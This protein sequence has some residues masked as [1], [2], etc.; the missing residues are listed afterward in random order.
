M[1]GT[2]DAGPATVNIGRGSVGQSLRQ[3]MQHGQQ[4]PI[5]VIQN[6]DDVMQ[7]RVMKEYVMQL[8]EASQPIN[9]QKA[10]GSR[11]EEFFQFCSHCY[12]GDPF[13]HNLTPEK[14]YRFVFF[15][16]F[17]EQKARGGGK[18]KVVGFEPAAYNKVMKHFEGVRPGQSVQNFPQPTNPISQSSFTTYKAVLRRIYTM[19]LSLGYISYHWDQLWLHPCKLVEQHV[20]ERKADSDKRLFKEK[21]TGEFSPY[22]VADKYGDIK[23][24]LW[25][26]ALGGCWRA[27]VSNLRH[28]SCLLYLTSGV[29]RCESLHR[30]DLSDFLWLR[31]PQREHDI[32]PMNI[33]INQIP[34]GKTN[35]CRVLYG[36]A[37]RHKDV[38]LCAVSAMSMYLQ[39]RFH[40]TR[41]FET[42][43]AEDWLDNSKWFNIKLL[44]DVTAPDKTIEMRNDSYGRHIKAILKDLRVVSNDL[45]HLGRKLGTKLLELL[46]AEVDEIQKMGQWME[47]FY[48]G[49]ALLYKVAS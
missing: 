29:L 28:R 6:P 16:A 40:T 12:E 10:Y 47:S 19:Q 30:A 25:V 13:K 38:R 45:C 18:N 41:E 39:A 24:R 32:H 22:L 31:V 34:K 26:D 49:R 1:A 8:T 35:K 5:A 23:E 14:V 15:L 21:I 3:P 17:R 9:T 7:E 36:R 20:K 42:F 2:V 43:T 4:R 11:V 27:V 46:E 37:T 44:V 48:N 33:M